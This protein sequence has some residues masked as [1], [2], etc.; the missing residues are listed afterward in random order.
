MS[1]MKQVI[2]LLIFFSFSFLRKFLTLFSELCCEAQSMKY[3][4]YGH[5]RRKM[6]PEEYM[7]KLMEYWD[8]D[9]K[10]L[11]FITVIEFLLFT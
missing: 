10:P 2:I 4:L 3:L 1:L 7:E 11:N 9:N 6:N 5:L 8:E